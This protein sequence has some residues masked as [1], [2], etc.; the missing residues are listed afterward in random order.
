[1][2]GYYG[3]DHASIYYRYGGIALQR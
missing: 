3:Q 2:H 1:M